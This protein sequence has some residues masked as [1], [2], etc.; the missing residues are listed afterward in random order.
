MSIL[1]FTGAT[2][3]KAIDYSLRS[4]KTVFR[5]VLRNRFFHTFVRSVI[6]LAL[7]YAA[8]LVVIFSPFG[9]WKSELVASMVF[10]GVTLWSLVNIIVTMINSGAL[11]V[12]IFREGSISDGII[13]F[14]E[15]KWLGARIGIKLYDVL[16]KGR[17][18][19]S[20]HFNQLPSSG[21][22]VRDYVSYMVKE[23]LLF[24]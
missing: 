17:G 21:D 18:E 8:I 7:I 9:E 20:S 14:V 10:I 5:D 4:G 22:V 11:I 19:F 16:R 1:N 3:S 24:G 6:K 12:W 2:L 23:V 13:Q 15:D